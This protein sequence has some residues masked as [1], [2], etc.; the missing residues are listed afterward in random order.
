MYN[1]EI[2]NQIV[3]DKIALQFRLGRLTVDRVSLTIG[4]GDKLYIN[5]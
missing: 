2:S 1:N 4:L 3:L 5:F